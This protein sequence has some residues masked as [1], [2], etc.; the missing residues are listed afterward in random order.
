MVGTV[1]RSRHTAYRLVY[2]TV[3]ASLGGLGGA[4]GYTNFP[5]IIPLSL[6]IHN[7]PISFHQT[8][9]TEDFL[10]VL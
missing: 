1:R 5:L 3:C 6:L 9:E 4:F 8:H 10:N 7:P 2:V